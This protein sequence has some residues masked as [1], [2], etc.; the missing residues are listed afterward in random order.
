MRNDLGDFAPSC[1]RY[2]TEQATQCAKSRFNCMNCKVYY[3]MESQP[4]QMKAAVLEL[5]KRFGK[6][7]N[8]VVKGSFVKN[9]KRYYFGFNGERKDDNRVSETR[10]D[11]G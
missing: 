4:C 1:I 8:E 6:P 7:K 5:F 11:N 10:Q 3:I 9:G 2:W